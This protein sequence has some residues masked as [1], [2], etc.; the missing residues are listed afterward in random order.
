[1]VSGLNQ[2]IQFIQTNPQEAIEIAKKEFPT[3][4][5][6]VIESAVNRMIEDNVYPKNVDIT[7]DALKVAMTTQI[8]I[9]NLA[10]QPVYEKFIERRYIS[11]ALEKMD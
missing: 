2:A 5:P 7:A 4:E 11:K 9:G 1:M 6:T 3:L 8:A 10:E